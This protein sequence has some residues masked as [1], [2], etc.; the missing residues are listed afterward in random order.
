M[1]MDPLQ[2]KR[3]YNSRIISCYIEFLEKFF[4][5]VAI[6]SLLEH[7]KI[8]R[9][10]VNDGGHWFTQ[11]QV[12]RFYEILQSETGDPDLA[13][14]AGRYITESQMCKPLQQYAFGFLS[15][16]SAYWMLEM[17]AVR[18][19]RHISMKTKKLST[20]RVEVVCSVREGVKER[21]YQC[22]NR[23]G[24]LESLSKV[25]TGR[26]ATVEHPECMHRGHSHCRY[27]VSW[28][29]PRSMALRRAGRFSSVAAG[30]A[31][32]LL[33]LLAPWNLALPASLALVFVPLGLYLKTSHLEKKDLSH[34]LEAQGNAADRLITEAN[35]HY[36]ELQLVQEIGQAISH[37][38]EIDS[39]L[40][41]IMDILNKRLDFGRGLVMLANEEKT[42]LQ[43]MAGFGYEPQQEHFLQS[44]AFHL[45]N[46]ESKGLFVLSFREKRPF[47]VDNVKNIT[48]GI[49]KR[50]LEFVRKMNVQSFVSVPILYEGK[51]LGVLAVDSPRSQ[52]PLSQS[53]L[54]LLMGIAP[55]IGISINNAKTY[56]MIR[57]REERFRALS[58]N[59]PDII[60]TLDLDGMFEYVNPAWERILGHET[61]EVIGRPISEFAGERDTL[62]YDSLFR[63]CLQKKETIRDFKG[64]LLHRDGGEK[65]FNLNAAPNLDGESN[66]MGIVG[67]LKDITDQSLLERQLQQAQKME[68][69]GTLTG[70]I[71][72]DFNNILQAISGYNQLMIMKKSNEENYRYLYSIGDLIQRGS[73]LIQQLMIFSRKVETRRIPI[74]VNQEIYKLYD[75]LSGTIHKMIHI[76]LDLDDDI[77][78][79][80][81]DA[82]QFGQII[83][84][85]VVNARDAMPE[86]GTLTI[87]TR[88]VPAS[89]LAGI[90]EVDPTS[91]RYVVIT[92]A[93]T[94]TGMDEETR[95][96]IFEP[97]FTTK[98]PGK[99]TGLGL[100]V[101][102]GIVKSHGGFIS[103]ESR[104]R[105]GTDFHIHLPAATRA[106]KREEASRHRRKT[107]WQ[108]TE[109]ILIVDDETCL[110]DTNADILKQNGYTTLTARNG[111]EAL[112]LFKEKTDDIDLVLLDLIMPGMGGFRCLSELKILHPSLRVLVTSGHGSLAEIKGFLADGTV[113][114]LQ[115]P[116]LFDDLLR[117]VRAFID[118]EPAPADRREIYP[119]GIG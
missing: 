102:Y 80:N 10:Q 22:D 4:P 106:A 51:A 67:I 28:K 83:M 88:L 49:S 42:R 98:L 110:L 75:I 85:L 87:R 53:D 68:A 97:F 41:E 11:S 60:F 115:K 50:S 1:S 29:S 6:D 77:Q 72:H 18:L 59:A 33:F 76:R 23:F 7:A 27:I 113:Q 36:N 89:R 116:Y 48:N 56:K 14:N 21:K 94:G 107:D 63:R 30:I 118:G 3:L 25:F 108:G 92:I 57:E 71:A 79:I 2:E 112:A 16:S 31:A 13:K 12:D 8:D 37:I 5:S 90:P 32:L 20:D 26:Y 52:R 55:Q 99:G 95:K 119:A 38:L 111:E 101:V 96:R 34:Y 35:R 24:M 81:G 46:P 17:F 73:S 61:E 62:V 65:Q 44:S 43:Y 54:N 91:E 105:K 100:A 58:E 70:G 69:I 40:K 82:G 78:E 64:R 45:D 47:L 66:V 103:C 93:D 9:H 19:S 109:T 39:L 84:N 104:L 86:G 15:P 117:T 114:F 74:D